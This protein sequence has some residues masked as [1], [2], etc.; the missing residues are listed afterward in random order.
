MLVA[1]FIALFIVFF[2]SFTGNFI[3]LILIRTINVTLKIY[4][5]TQI[6]VIFIFIIKITVIFVVFLL[7][8]VS[9]II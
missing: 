8:D 5:L 7:H 2:S 9:Q 3:L 4:M 6:E 1:L